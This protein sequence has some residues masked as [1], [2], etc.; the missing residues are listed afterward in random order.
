MKARIG[1][2]NFTCIAGKRVCARFESRTWIAG[3]FALCSQKMQAGFNDGELVGNEN[4]RAKA[5]EVS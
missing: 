1:K 5:A 2:L 3:G 4:W